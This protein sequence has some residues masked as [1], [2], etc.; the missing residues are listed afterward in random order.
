MLSMPKVVNLRSQSGNVAFEVLESQKGSLEKELLSLEK[1]IETNLYIISE[2]KANIVNLKKNKVVVS[3]V[4]YR[5]IL[6]E[7]SYLKNNLAV[8]RDVRKK[9]ES[10]LQSLKKITQKKEGKVIRLPIK[11]AKTRRSRKKA[12]D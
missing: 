3:L 10:D 11:K 8:L 12:K 4:E 9:N 2:L 7:L 6:N 1:T 5:K